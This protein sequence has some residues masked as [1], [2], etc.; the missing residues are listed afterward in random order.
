MKNGI[1]C[2]SIFFVKLEITEDAP[3]L[4]SAC[5]VYSYI[6][7]PPTKKV[8]TMVFDKHMVMHDKLNMYF[9]YLMVKF[10]STED[11]AYL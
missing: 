6:T 5:I 3:N 9:Y 2:F 10:Q 11:A 7:I 4:Y 8:A 1:C